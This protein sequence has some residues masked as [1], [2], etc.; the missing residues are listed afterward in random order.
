MK[1]TTRCTG[2]RKVVAQF[3]KELLRHSDIDYQSITI[4]TPEKSEDCYVLIVT[5]TLWDATV[6][7]MALSY[8]R[9]HTTILQEI[10]PD[11]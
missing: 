4:T 5:D 9:L 11:M 10:T 1:I 7:N 6:E 8:S 3:V 2:R